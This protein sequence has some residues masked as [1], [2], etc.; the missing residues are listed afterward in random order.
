MDEKKLRARVKR[1]QAG[2]L[3]AFESLYLEHAR[4]IL[5]H[6][7]S[8]IVDKQNYRDVAQDVALE[9]LRDI[10]KLKEPAAFRGWMHRIVR[11][12]C[13]DHN[14]SL[15]SEE[16]HRSKEDCEVVLNY[17]E[18]PGSDGDPEASVMALVSREELFEAIQCL[19]DAYREAMVLR[20]YDELSYKE[21]AQVQGITTSTVGTN[22]KRATESLRGILESRAKEENM[23]AETQNPGPQNPGSH[24]P[25]PHN[26]GRGATSSAAAGLVGVNAAGITESLGF[27]IS[28]AVP[29]STI[30]SFSAEFRSN[31]PWL[32]HNLGIVLKAKGSS[33]LPYIL[34]VVTVLAL[35][36]IVL[37]VF[38][39]IS[40]GNWSRISGEVSSSVDEERQVF[41]Y[42]GRAHIEFTDA[43]GGNESVGVISIVAV[44]DSGNAETI[45]WVVSNE[46]GQIVLQ[47]HG[48]VIDQ[49]TL[50][51]LPFG[52]YKVNYT[53]TD[54]KG[55]T[56]NLSRSFTRP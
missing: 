20:F 32:S 18:E 54:T 22:L 13:Y 8:L 49:D 3:H 38:A 19:P 34:T 16:A 48:P 15:M 40:Q 12:T 44:E 1:A 17:L 55:A 5:F 33:V 14:R 35:V 39:F 27:G 45:N 36:A 46:A 9:M 52:T 42:E 23:S 21:I 51:P 24:N 4:S 47:G 53:F 31:L 41:V 30:E 2:D 56:A 43:S 10:G 6:V 37:G 25:G 26:P 50:A 29:Q 7:R 28:Q 11:T